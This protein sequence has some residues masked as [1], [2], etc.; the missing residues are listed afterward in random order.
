[1]HEN[2]VYIETPL[3][4]RKSYIKKN[5]ALKYCLNYK[6]TCK[7]LLTLIVKKINTIV[8]SRM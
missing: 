8:S 6:I 2:F 1:M 4:L 3:E 5:L 7:K